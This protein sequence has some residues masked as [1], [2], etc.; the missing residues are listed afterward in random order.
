MGRFLSTD[1]LSREL[2]WNSCYAFAENRPIDGI[3]FEGSEYT[4][5]IEKYQYKSVNSGWDLLDNVNGFIKNVGADIYNAS[6]S[7]CNAVGS[8]AVNTYNNG[9]VNTVHKIGGKA[10]QAYVNIKTGVAAGVNDIASKSLKENLKDAGN[11]FLNPANYELPVE[12][13]LTGAASRVKF[14]SLAAAAKPSASSMIL[15]AL[16]DGNINFD[17]LR[18]MIPE[19]TENT[20]KPSANIAGGEKYLFEYQ[21]QQV[22]LKWHTPD[23]GAAKKYPGSNSGSY[24]TAQVKLNGKLLDKSGTF[25]DKASNTTHIP[26]K[27]K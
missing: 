16:E 11:A 26:L 24:N 13:A 19:G 18:K 6:S 4:P 8:T 9:A 22:E 14:P 21:G 5:Y 3:D 15:G 20:F 17:K 23:A 10:E 1:P 7:L 27:E 12:L 25:V 2:P